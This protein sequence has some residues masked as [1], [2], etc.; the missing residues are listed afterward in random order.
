MAQPLFDLIDPHLLRM[1]LFKWLD[2]VGIVLWIGAIG[3]RLVVFSPVLKALRRPALESRL[4]R[5]EAAYTEPA[6]QGVLLYL[7]ILHLATWVH[8]AEMMSGKP[9]SEIGPVLPIVL[10]KTHFGAIWEVKLFLLLF[11]FVLVRVR[12]PARDLLLFGAGL[13]LCVTGSLVGH[14]YTHGGERGAVLTDWVHFSAVSVWI[15]GLLPLRRMARK[16]ASFM[17]P[18]PLALYLQLLIGRFSIVAIL[19]VALIAA[20]GAY[21]AALFLDR[22][23]IFDFTYGQILSM[24]LLMAAATIGMGGISRF[25]L[26]PALSK[27]QDAAP[28]VVSDL[29]RRFFRYLTIEVALAV[30]T[31]LLAAL[32]TQT[33]P[34][35]P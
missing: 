27:A 10:S 21:N 28:L 31:L 12:I 5:E 33:A 17:E 6:L 9:L 24:K 7:L 29:E 8:Q 14:P 18:A 3:F 35:P 30:A 15:G 11:L 32:L 34:P 25:Y 4:R 13:F 20:S 26:L 22:H 1:T 19:A 2:L 16:A 23:W